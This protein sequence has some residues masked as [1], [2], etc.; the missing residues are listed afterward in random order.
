MYIIYCVSRNKTCFRDNRH[1]FGMKHLGH[2]IDINCKLRLQKVSEYT[3]QCI[4]TSLQRF[5]NKS[6]A[7]YPAHTMLRRRSDRWSDSK[8]GSGSSSSNHREHCLWRLRL[9][10]STGCAAGAAGVAEQVSWLRVKQN[11]KKGWNAENRWNLMKFRC[12]CRFYQIWIYFEVY[13]I[14]NGS[15]IGVCFRYVWVVRW[16]FSFGT[17]ET[18]T[19]KGNT[20]SDSGFYQSN[21]LKPPCYEHQKNVSLDSQVSERF[22][23]IL[24]QVTWFT[25]K[26]LKRVCDPDPSSLTI[27]ALKHGKDIIGDK[28][29]IPF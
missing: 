20:S 25:L 26:I 17:S 16:K 12:S 19:M 29:W 18:P 11:G 14:L 4:V 28:A 21:W 9:Q 6:S 23:S 22:T 24:L 2:C 8:F 1:F 3:E 5:Q 27:V 13:P 7:P 15:P 10:P